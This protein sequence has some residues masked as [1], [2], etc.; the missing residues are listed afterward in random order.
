MNPKAFLLL[1]KGAR[2]SFDDWNQLKDYIFKLQ[3]R[4]EDLEKSRSNWKKKYNEL[5]N[6]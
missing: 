5:K 2:I 1:E 6:K 4:I 3:L